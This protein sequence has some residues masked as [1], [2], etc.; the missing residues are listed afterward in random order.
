MEQ[1]SI[2]TSRL[3]L[4]A[5]EPDDAQAVQQL[6]NNPAIASNTRSL[7]YP[8]NEKMARDWINSHREK[9]MAGEQIN[10]AIT[11]LEEAY[12]IGAIGLQL[13]MEHKRAELG[14]WLGEPYW[15]NGYCTEAAQAT[16]RFGFEHLNLNRIYAQT[17][18]DNKASERILQKA[19]MQYEG[20]LRQHIRKMDQY[21]DVIMYAILRSEFIEQY[22]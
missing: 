12:F 5:F 8:Y 22:G 13:Q 11:H 14:Y 2:Q 15:N 7:P 9:F 18:K 20:Y 19:G 3:F 17:F 4:R 16:I 21:E 6:A 1:P 10:F